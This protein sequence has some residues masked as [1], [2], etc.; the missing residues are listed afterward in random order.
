M[1]DRPPHLRHARRG[2]AGTACGS[3]RPSPPPRKPAAVPRRPHRLPGL[4]AAALLLVTAVLGGSARAERR[5]THFD[6][7]SIEDGLSQGVVWALAQD[8]EGFI[9]IGTEEGLN[10]FDGYRFVTYRPRA[11]DP[12]SLSGLWVLAIHEDRLGRLWIATRDGGLNRFDRATGRF[13]RFRHDPAD[14]SSLPS[15]QVTRILEEPDGTMWLAT[16]RGLARRGPEGRGFETFRHDPADPSSLPDDTVISLAAGQGDLWVGT[17]RG[18]A[19]LDRTTGR[20][21]R[22]PVPHPRAGRAALLPALAHDRVHALHLDRDGHLWVGSGA[23][24]KWLDLTGSA[25]RWSAPFGDPGPDLSTGPISSILEASGGDI[26]IGVR[27]GG[28]HRLDHASRRFVHYTADPAD[29][30]SLSDP[31]VICLLEDRDRRL[32]VGTERG[33]DKVEPGRRVFAHYRHDPRDPSSLSENKVAGM[34]EDHRGRIWIATRGGGLN[35]FDPEQETFVAFR[36]DPRRPD[37]LSH[38]EVWSITEDA[39]GRLW[40]GT[41]DA[42]LHRFDPEQGRF[43]R[44]P[45]PALPG[46]D[47][48]RTRAADRL[49]DLLADRNG[50][51]WIALT[52]G[53]LVRFDPR[54]AAF[55][56]FRHDP[57]DPRSLSHDDVSDI[58]EDRRGRLWVATDGGGLNR[59]DRATGTFIRYRH[60]PGNPRSLGHD[61]VSVIHEDPAGTL[62]I[63]TYGAG[64]DRFD[65]ETG[66]FDHV[67]EANGLPNAIV[68][69]IADA[70]DGALFLSTNKGLCRFHPRTGSVE[71]FEASHGLQGTEFGLKAFL[72]ARNG[73]LYFGGFNGFNAFWPELVG[74]DRNAPPVVITDFLIANRSMAPRW[75]DPNSPLERPIGATRELTLSYRHAVI[76]FEFAALHYTN[77]AR[78]RYAYRLEGFDADWI[79]TSA[80]KRVATYTNLPPGRYTF[81]VRAANLDGV[82]N[83]EGASLALIV[84][85]PFWQT[86]WFKASVG[87]AAIGLVVAFVQGR[88]RRLTRQRRKLEVLVARRTR[89]LVEANAWLADANRRLADTNER[90]AAINRELEEARKSALAAARAKSEFLANMSHEIRTP[91]NGVLGYAD[92]LDATPLTAEQR[93]YVATIRTSGQALLVV[94]NDILDMSKI[95]AGRID[96]EARPFGVRGCVEEALDLVAPQAAEKGLD[97]ACLVAPDVPA[98]IVGDP[99]RLRQILGNLLSNAVKFTEAGEV[100]VEVA[101]AGRTPSGVTL[102]CTVRDTGIGI[103]PD[104]VGRLFEAFTQGDASTTRRYGGTGLGLSIS[105][106]L[107]ELMGGTLSVESAPGLGSAFAFTLP[108]P[109]AHAPDEEADRVAAGRLAGRRVL[110]VDDHEATRRMLVELLSTWG[111]SAVAAGSGPEA[112]AQ[113]NGGGRFDAVLVDRRLPDLDGPLVAAEVRR[114]TQ[115]PQLPV[116][117]LD[118]L[119]PPDDGRPEASAW[120]RKPVKPER[121]R[122]TLLDLLVPDRAAGEPPPARVPAVHEDVRSLSVLLAEDNIINAKLALRMLARLGHTGVLASNGREVLS[123]LER[124]P[125]D[126]V[127]MDVQMPELDGL[128]AAR[129]IARRWGDERPPIVALTASVMEDDVR[130]CREAGMNDV[131]AK[132]IVLEDL[133]EALQRAT[134]HRRSRAT[135]ARPAAFQSGAAASGAGA[136]P[137]VA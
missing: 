8:R 34:L 35:R 74:P 77:P 76:A 89:E 30:R 2:P 110:V 31:S 91:M 17:L 18:L 137:E 7:L 119:A 48:S 105:K 116:V 86:A 129:E 122:D 78:N 102:R 69:G 64:I 38:D 88:T 54:T 73:R 103:P 99:M 1:R 28:L 13:T 12:G 29:P 49:F 61:A 39:A 87:A 53:G 67:T 45:V 95:E 20:F 65:P 107:V 136:E 121:L 71:V 115:D 114:R 130:R 3:R 132:P 92:L 9:W 33:L 96:L 98:R 128:E 36:H 108:V 4:V 109:V 56:G 14:P 84:L 113:V 15:D 63:G 104:R 75:L 93:D 19:R 118:A 120:L 97:L 90:L 50:V 26:W 52:G 81:R 131:L 66:T 134:R 44:F 83:D 59:L 10:R 123:A 100:V 70:G 112:L 46:P 80:T 82:W 57:R 127:L 124:Q 111:V 55:S 42:T 25:P 126:V 72:Q 135:P 101:V 79:P 58:F 133:A 117:M 85:P 43:V 5:Q 60:D 47:G 94:L 62:W 27:G 32:W 106:R 21:V 23:G 51:L 41:R 37:S 125:F 40:V 24:L 6:R 22:Y 68:Y 16:N 11:G